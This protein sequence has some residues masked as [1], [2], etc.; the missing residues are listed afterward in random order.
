VSRLFA[1]PVAVAVVLSLAP[2]APVP[3]G[4]EK[5]R[6]YFPTTVGAKWVY[7]DE[8]GDVTE[9]VTAVGQA[10]EATVVTV[11]RIGPD[12][13]TVP[14]AKWA[15]S[16][17]GLFLLEYDG[18]KRDPPHCYLKLPLQP[19]VDWDFELTKPVWRGSARKSERIQV[20]AGE[21]DAIA[22]DVS[23]GKRPPILSY[24][25]AAGIG[26]VKKTNRE[27][28]SRILKSFTPGKD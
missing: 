18:I 1:A 14:V 24:W 23:V 20:P 3:K 7:Q 10:E 8:G 28:T 26:F 13:K 16:E 6:L 4:A 22:V 19:G 25:L 5:S 12:G 11:G 17:R 9:V 21:Y 27:N 2:A 15:V